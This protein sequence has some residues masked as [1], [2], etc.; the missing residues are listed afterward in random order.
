MYK[1]EVSRIVYSDFTNSAFS[2]S[3]RS[4]SMICLLQLHLV[5]T[6]RQES[7]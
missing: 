2:F 4:C 1:V 7:R 6:N 3:A 5:S